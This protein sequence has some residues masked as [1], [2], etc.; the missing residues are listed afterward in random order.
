[1]YVRKNRNNRLKPYIL[2]IY[3]SND[4]GERGK[5]EARATRHCVGKS[6]QEKINQHRYKN[7]NKHVK[8]TQNVQR[9][10]HSE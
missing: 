4:K 3:G 8:T 2:N 1:M 7:H 10:N 6:I 5:E 9:R